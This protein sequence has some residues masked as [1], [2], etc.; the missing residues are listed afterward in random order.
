MVA[1]INDR[2][3]QS[4]MNAIERISQFLDPLWEGLSI[5]PGFVSL[6]TSP[7][8]VLQCLV[9]SSV[10][11]RKP[12]V[13]SQLVDSLAVVNTVHQ[14]Y[15]LLRSVDVNFQ[16]L[17]SKKAS[18]ITS[19]AGDGFLRTV[20]NSY[21][22]MALYDPQFGRDLAHELDIQLPADA[23]P[24]EQA[25]IIAHGWRFKTLKR[26]IMDG[27]MELRVHGMETMQNELVNIFNQFIRGNPAG[28][29][30]PVPQYLVSFI[31][32]NKII[33]Y[34]VGVDSHPQL[35]SRSGNVVGFLVVALAYNDEDSDVIWRSVTESQDP[36]FVAEVLGM[37][38]RTVH[39]MTSTEPILYLCSKLLE[40]PMD[41]FDLRMID[42]FDN[43]VS[44][45]R[46]KHYD[47]MRQDNKTHV[48]ATAVRLCV[49]LIR[50]ADSADSLSPEQKGNLQRAAGK[51]I[52]QLLTLGI[53]DKDKMKIFRQCTQ[54]ISEMN[55]FASG[56]VHA[57][58]A[59]TSPYEAKDVMVLAMD[60][61]LIRVLIN[62][63]AKTIEDLS[64]EP[65]DAG[66][67]HAL[68]S[69]LQLLLRI[70]DKAPDTITPESCELLWASLFMSDKVQDNTRAIAW[71]MLQ[72]SVSRCAKR[73]S[74]LERIMNDFLPYVPPERYTTQVL[75]FAEQAVNYE[76]RF[77]RYRTYNE[78]E[79]ISI[80]GIERIWHFILT[81]PP[82]TVEMRAINFAIDVYLDERSIRNAPRSAAEAT[83]VAL[84]DRCVEQLTSAANKLK[85]FCEGTSSGEDEPM[86]IIPSEGEVRI[87]ELR[88]SRSL[89]F[90]RQLLHGLRT[91]PHYTPAQG[92]PPQLLPREDDIKG[93]PIELSYQA[94]TNNTST[95]IRKLRIGDLSTASELVDKIV[96]LTGFTKFSAFK[97]GQRLDLFQS[98]RESLRDLKVTSGLLIIRCHPDAIEA[99][100]GGRRQ[101]LTL[102]DSEVLKHFDDLHD[103]LT[104]D[105]RLSKEVSIPDTLPRL[106][107]SV[108]N[109]SL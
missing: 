54:D 14:A 104:L 71:D 18:W 33:E 55:S 5:W 77:D 28:V 9:E 1:R 45:F 106:W 27:R 90:L 19:E 25:H 2:I 76:L 61:D 44:Q 73:N 100:I 36:R 94:F 35:V 46:D 85:G 26:H 103:L 62:E 8:H 84:V 64:P 80:P 23:A 6:F 101:S 99:S 56:S 70:T 11:R 53:S 86:V 32:E 83:H 79:V 47:R 17:T 59:L 63:I 38:I 37:L 75:A 7:L 13:D 82:G 50:E 3:T 91:R 105:E 88:F 69:R 74:F 49:R 81:A 67:K 102:V 108:T 40:L 109:G 24:E 96:R 58:M 98:P 95:Q 4:P 78:D 57:L 39:L 34:I 60:F 42:Y 20:G 16:S 97:S 87:E 68:M 48:D 51:Q 30:N 66:I 29:N 92:S 10:E 89:L 72:K 22:A 21:H 31:R 93:E 43:L 41:R 52:A 12:H 107:E 65:S 15:R